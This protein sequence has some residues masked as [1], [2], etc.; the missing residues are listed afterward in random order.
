MINY[1]VCKDVQQR[2]TDSREQEKGREAFIVCAILYVVV[3]HRGLAAVL[4][5]RAAFHKIDR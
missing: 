5:P 4:T 2:E 1:S 3:D